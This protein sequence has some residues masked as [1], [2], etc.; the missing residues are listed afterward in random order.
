MLAQIVLFDGFDPLDVIAPFEVLA[1][2]SDAV[3]GDLEVR[4]VGIDATGPVTSG[5]LV[6]TSPT[7]RDGSL[8]KRMSRLVTMPSRVMSRSTTGTPEIR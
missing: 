4:L 2:G 7:S 1:A 5:I 3:G 6:I 8:S